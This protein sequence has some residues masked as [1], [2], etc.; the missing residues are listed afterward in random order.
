VFLPRQSA[1]D[2]SLEYGRV[3]QHTFVDYTWTSQ[4]TI[5]LDRTLWPSAHVFASGSGGLVGVE[6]AVVNRGRQTG[7]RAEGGVRFLRE[8]GIVD[9][10]SAYERRVDGHPTSRQP[11]S[12]FEFGF[13]LGAP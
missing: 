3:V 8:R 1:I 2:V 6:R 12:W 4:V 7:A 10:F 13:R 11:A 9:F 5:R